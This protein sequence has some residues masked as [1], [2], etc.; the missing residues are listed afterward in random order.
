MA[1]KKVKFELTAVDK[2][3][4]AFDKVSK[5][6]KSVGSGAKMAGIGVAKVGLAA[7]G[8][9]AALAIFSQR[10]FEAIDRLGK[11]AS[12]LGVNVELLQE[13]RFAAEQT[14]I[15]QRTLDMALQRFIRRV[16]EA[17][18]G[19]GEAKG[20]LKDLGIQLKDNEGNL[21]STRDILGDVADGIMNTE[22]SSEQ[23]RLSFKF[24]DSEGA[25]LVNTLKN[26]KKGLEDYAK[27]AQSLGFIL[28]SETVANTEK[29]ADQV[30]V[31][32]RQVTG[33][34][35]YTLA[36]FLPVLQDIAKELSGILKD[37]AMQNGGF[38]VLGREIAINLVKALET[39]VILIANVA[40]S[41]KSISTFGF[42]EPIADVQALHD[43]FH[44]LKLRILAVKEPVKDLADTVEQ[45]TKEKILPAIESFKQGLGA[46]EDN[47][48]KAATGSMKQ[49][50]DS[51]VNSLKSGKLEFKNFAD[52]VIEQLLRIAIQEL[53][54]KRISGTFSS[55]FSDFGN[56][57][58]KIP[59][60]D[61]GGYTGM[62]ARAGGVDGKGGF[63]AILHPN[64]TIIDHTKGQ[65]MGTTVNFNISTVDAAGFDQLLASR[66]GLITSIINNAMN[67]QGKMGVV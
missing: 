59:S 41:L 54:I 65:G 5:G 45:E 33:F 9:A 49:F 66:K 13:M 30:N 61:G 67:N 63:P 50:E 6:L 52:Y 64:E 14:G 19:T 42:G 7:T 12:K 34:V 56:I 4:A 15:E 57:F 27:E 35:Q 29:F 23:L 3:K 17:A 55:M 11:T 2:T 37:A 18:K 48:G 62:G 53:I 46:V 40:N 25:A 24:F 31:V 1:N 20:A 38:K 60:G 43:T 22:S 36:S 39:V 10:N 51:I 26:G 58:K 44:N 21:R 16:G 8:A 32:K 28:D 47:L